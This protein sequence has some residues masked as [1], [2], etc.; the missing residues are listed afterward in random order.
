MQFLLKACYK[1]GLDTIIY[2]LCFTSQRLLYEVM[3]GCTGLKHGL[4]NL[5]PLWFSLFLM[6]NS[7][8]Q[9]LPLKRGG[10]GSCL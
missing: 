9:T 5:N 8:W 2:T 4:T 1:G 6:E 3:E 10:A 7:F